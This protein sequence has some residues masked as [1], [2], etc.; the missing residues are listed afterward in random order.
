MNRIDSLGHYTRFS[1]SSFY[2]E[3]CVFCGTTD[4]YGGRLDSAC[5]RTVP[6][7]ATEYWVDVS[8]GMP[9]YEVQRDFVADPPRYRWRPWKFGQPRDERPEWTVDAPPPPNS[10]H[11]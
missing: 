2:D 7:D 10:H 8:Y 9:E 6:R 4:G 3:V 11:A 5:P 1:D